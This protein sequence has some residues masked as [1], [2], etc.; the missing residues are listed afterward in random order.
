M[1]TFDVTVED[2]AG[3]VWEGAYEGDKIEIGDF[4]YV[5]LHTKMPT[6]AWGTVIMFVHV[7]GENKC[8]M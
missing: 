6:T 3:N 8:Q 5:T 1:K 2:D 7:S 4:V